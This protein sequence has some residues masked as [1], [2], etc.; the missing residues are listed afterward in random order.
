LN[1]YFSL[2]NPNYFQIL[3]NLKKAGCLPLDILC[4]TRKYSR[5]TRYPIL[6]FFVGTYSLKPGT[7]IGLDDASRLG[8]KGGI[9]DLGSRFS[10]M[11]CGRK[12]V[13]APAY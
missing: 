13:I 7:T 9:P 2:R 1:Q 6:I 10:L 8:E 11:T 4:K 5:N 12:R 3:I